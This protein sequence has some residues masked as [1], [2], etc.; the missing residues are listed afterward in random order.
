ML[1]S[2][3]RINYHDNNFIQWF[4]SKCI[5]LPTF[6]LSHSKTLKYTTTKKGQKTHYQKCKA[7]NDFIPQSLDYNQGAKVFPLQV[8]AQQMD[9]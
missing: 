3:I 5:K 9:D 1:H 8:L 4:S 6:F 7:S 2:N